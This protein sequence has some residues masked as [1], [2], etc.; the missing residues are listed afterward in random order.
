[1]AANVPK[2]DSKDP[3]DTEEDLSNGSYSPRSVDGKNEV[4]WFAE[5][6]S[7]IADIIS[8]EDYS[9]SR[10]IQHQPPLPAQHRSSS[11]VPAKHVQTGDKWASKS[12]D[13]LMCDKWGGEI[14]R[15]CNSCI[16]GRQQEHSEAGLRRQGTGSL[17]LA[18]LA[19]YERRSMTVI[20]FEHGGPAERS[21][22][23]K[24]GDEVVLIGAE[25]IDALLGESGGEEA[26]YQLLSGEPGIRTTLTLRRREAGYSAAN[27]RFHPN[28]VVT[29]HKVTLTRAR[30]RERSLSHNPKPQTVTESYSLVPIMVPSKVGDRSD[31]LPAI[32]E[33]SGLLPAPTSL[34]TAVPTSSLDMETPI[35]ARESPS[36]SASSEQG[37]LSG[38]S[39]AVD[40]TR[41]ASD[42]TRAA[43][44]EPARPNFVPALWKPGGGT[45]RYKE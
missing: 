28:H 37:F 44:Q 19:D 12:G 8:P 24:I 15:Y 5:L 18:L 17:G 34:F 2:N 3:F 16:S 14:E 9:G 30:R 29:D 21:G 7:D 23:V 26:I 43:R 31:D 35:S 40:P 45:P 25:S 39:G 11:S 10:K 36:P 42:S 1:M 20:G 33:R 38:G 13:L 6:L 27:E 22:R 32:P 4:G 41:G